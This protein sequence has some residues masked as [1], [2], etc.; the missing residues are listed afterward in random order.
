MDMIPL[1]LETLGKPMMHLINKKR[2]FK[3]VLRRF[4]EYVF[5]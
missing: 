5:K 4:Q 3:G 1:K 2:A